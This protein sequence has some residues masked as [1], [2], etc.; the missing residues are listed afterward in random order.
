MGPAG[1][2]FA[3]RSARGRRTSLTG[4]Y[5][6][7]L[8]DGRVGVLL[9][10][11]YEKRDRSLQ[12]LEENI[13]WQT[14]D[15]GT[16]LDSS[17]PDLAALIGAAYPG[18]PRQEQRSGSADKLNLNA[19][20]QYAATDTLELSLNG[21]YTEESRDEDRARIQV[22]F[23]RGRLRDGAL[24]ASGET[25]TEGRFD[26]QRV[27]MLNFTR[28][29]DIE[30]VGATGGFEWDPDN[31]KVEGELSYSSSEENFREWR[32][33]TRVNRDGVGGY[34]ITADPQYPVVD[35]PATMADPASLSIQNLDFQRRIIS[36]DESA[37]KLDAERQL[38][39]GFI[40]SV[41]FGGRFSS[42]EYDRKQGQVASPDAGGL[43]YADGE[44]GFV[45]DG[46][47]AQDF[48][49]AGILNMW[50]TVDPR[51]FYEAHPSTDTFVFD[52]ENLWTI[53]EDTSAIYGM[54]NFSADT[55]ALFLRGNAGVRGV[56]TKYSGQGRVNIQSTI[57]PDEFDPD[58]N[59]EVFLDDQP[60]IDRDYT[61]WLPS[62]NVVASAHDG[63]PFQVRAAISRALS[64]PT[65][66]EINPGVEV[67]TDDGDIVRGNP[68]LDPF[69]AWQYDLG[70]EYYFTGDKE[71][72]LTATLFHKDVKNFIAPV[73]YS[74]TTAFPQV[75]LPEQTYLV[76]TFKNGGEATIQG[77]EIGVQTPFTFLPGFWRDFGV[78][79]NYT[80]TDSEF[81]DDN[82]NAFR[83]PG[84][85]ENAYNLVAY[86][87]R[88][89]F[90]GR[91]AY[92]FR[93]DF[94]QTTS[95]NADGS[96]AIY[97]EEQGRLD[98]GLRY[99]FENGLRLSFDALNLTE[100]QAYTYY[101][102]ADRYQSL[103]V[104]GRIYTV[105]LGWVF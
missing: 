1:R 36:L 46:S 58:G 21:F 63:A 78:Y 27:D 98:L 80:Y 10:G 82:G 50:P 84:A 92:A 33:S 79:A 104:E 89:G 29:A 77:V 90:S 100:E 96:N 62:F 65:I 102:R 99:R 64:R 45:L 72:G 68:A 6:N 38:G 105:G 4:F 3:G 71:G 14:V 97:G 2:R 54:A 40:S 22:D 37:A 103:D 66:N 94:L 83:F 95:G 25:L 101:D 73:T 59:D 26:R 9:A 39:S 15:A 48:A 5:S 16:L 75:G 88:G 70:F 85:S 35:T 86:Y 8:A 76:S 18:R 30:T 60:S 56:Q 69:T 61:E 87:E 7:V 67:N 17:D 31:W 91:L 41:K 74:E 19:K 13:G 12:K 34:S 32:A 43:T 24:D 42:A 44:P 52:D 49:P 55:G 81:V 47:F 93:S 57:L 23:S 53:T 11:T 28:L 51:P 20:I